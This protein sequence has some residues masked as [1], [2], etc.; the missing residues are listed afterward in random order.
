MKKNKLLNILIMIL[1]IIGALEGIALVNHIDGTCFNA[2]IGLFGAVAGGIITV[3]FK[4]VKEKITGKK[5]GDY[6]VAP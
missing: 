3:L 4:Q 1:L 6:K 5:A 2:V